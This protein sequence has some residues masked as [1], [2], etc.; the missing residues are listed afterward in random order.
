MTEAGIVDPNIDQIRKCH[1]SIEGEN[2][3]QAIGEE[4]LNLD[5]GLYFVPW[6][7]LDEV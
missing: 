6:I 5:P 1:D 3:L 4:T 7:T 2:L